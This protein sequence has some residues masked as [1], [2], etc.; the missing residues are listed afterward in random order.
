[1][2]ERKLRDVG[3]LI[4]NRRYQVL[5]V[6]HSSGM[7]AVYKVRDSQLGTVWCLK[8]IDKEQAGR[9][10]IEYRSLLK[11]ARIMRNLNHPNIPRI[12]TIEEEDSSIFIVMDYVKGK[13]LKDILN[14]KKVLS[15]NQVI[16]IMTQVAKVLGYLHSFKSPIVYRDLKPSNTMLLSDGSVRLLDFGISEEI[17]EENKYIKE[18][19]GTWGFAAPEQVIKGGV[20]DIRS[21]IFSF[22][23]TCYT[24]LTGVIP[25]KGKNVKLKPI[26]EIN[27]SVSVG[28]ERF[29]NKCME[30]DPDKRFQNFS[31]VLRDL[32]VVDKDNGKYKFFQWFKMIFSTALLVLAIVF[33]V[34]GIVGIKNESQ[35]A[36]KEYLNALEVARK[37]DK[38]EDWGTAIQ[39]FPDRLDPYFEMIEAIKEDGVFSP[40][41]EEVLLNTISPVAQDIQ[42][43]AKY[44]KLSFAIGEMYW[45][46]LN[47]DTKAG[48]WLYDAGDNNETAKILFNLTEF[49]RNLRSAVLEGKDN[50][51][52]QEY[53]SNLTKA[54]KVDNK[55]IQLAADSAFVDCVSSYSVKLRKDNVSKEDII[56]VLNEIKSQREGTK[57]ENKVQEGYLK[58][59]NDKLESAFRSVEVAYE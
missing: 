59:I 54:R 49:N 30:E 37:S 31:E 24:L 16:S 21:D 56:K 45:L 22:G 12:V 51:L 32:A 58:N 26:R 43:D 41:E 29:L 48:K 34:R 38:I 17:T 11:E 9:N 47:G 42:E 5:D 3:S 50:G 39:L 13:S 8:E 6:I 27:S 46:Y 20:L 55:V 44:P 14:S 53:F 57:A 35:T 28:F 19:L 23:R 25:P 4:L 1:M 7:S 18:A 33:T 40:E 15:Q 36:E 10:K 52:Y 2:R